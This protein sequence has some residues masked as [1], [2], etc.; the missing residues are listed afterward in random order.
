MSFSLHKNDTII[1][2]GLCKLK[3]AIGISST[4]EDMT[5]LTAGSYQ[6]FYLSEA[7]PDA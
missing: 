3:L 1:S 4:P 5:I 2:S 7:Y 6:T